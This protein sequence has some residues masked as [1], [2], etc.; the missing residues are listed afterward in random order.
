MFSGYEIVDVNFTD[1]KLLWASAFDSE[2]TSNEREI[3]FRDWKLPTKGIVI[4][5]SPLNMNRTFNLYTK[6]VCIDKWL[7]ARDYSDDCSN[8]KFSVHFLSIEYT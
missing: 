1:K 3:Q 8:S 6:N 4:E 2:L 7:L 5:N